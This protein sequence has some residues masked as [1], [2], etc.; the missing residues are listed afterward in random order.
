MTA[1][2]LSAQRWQHQSSSWFYGRV[3]GGWLHLSEGI[4]LAGDRAAP[5][6]RHWRECDGG[7]RMILPA[8]ASPR[9]A[10]TPRCYASVGRS[11]NVPPRLT[12][13]KTKTRARRVSKI[14]AAYQFR[15]AH[16]APCLRCP[17]LRGRCFISGTISCVINKSGSVFSLQVTWIFHQR[18][19]VQRGTDVHMKRPGFSR[20]T[21][22]VV[23][24]A[25]KNGIGSLVSC[26]V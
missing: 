24:E 3:V 9:Y 4:R 14:A 6:Q 23:D 10:I 8:R 18:V 5:R 22:R 19:R 13:A 12:P 25:A 16:M 26:C 17:Q 21:A 15:F 20:Q 2:P 11:G 7:R 1:R